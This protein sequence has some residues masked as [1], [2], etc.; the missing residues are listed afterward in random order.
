[1]NI[2]IKTIESSYIV[3]WDDYVRAHPRSTLYHLSGWKNVIEKTYGHKTYYLM[4]IN[5]SK[6]KAQS[7]KKIRITANSYEPKSNRVVG[8][9]P[10][11]HLK[12]FLFDNSLISIPFFDLGGILADDVDAEKALLNEAIKIGHNLDVKDI[13]LRH[14]EP[15]SWLNKSSKLQAPS[16]V[17]TLKSHEL[18][19]ISYATKTHKVRMLLDLPASSEILMKSFKAKLRSQIKK[20]LKEGLKATVD[21]VE[22]LDDFYR[23]FTINMRDLGS[24][25]HSRKLMQNVL[26]EFPD[27]SK[28]VMIYKDGQPLACSLMVGFKGTLENPWASAL[29]EYSRLS[30]NML[31]YWTM[32]EH[33]CDNGYD[34]FDFGRSSPEEGT[35]K[36]KEQWGAKPTSLHWHSISLEGKSTSNAE[37][38]EKSGFDKAIRY[39]QKLPVS[40][41]KII[42]PLIRKHIGL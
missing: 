29:R 31:L 32:L 39:W 18:P 2:E 4:A 11:V 26:K 42:G 22:L 8:L 16:S 17:P 21:G 14:I 33:A 19:P 3:A 13:E 15:L 23:V 30:P 37:A 9:L 7:S 20:P 1:M 24:P 27:K 5:S 10:L 28:I 35:Y 25:G 6:L 34:H 38:S 41:T 40:I 36:F 12:H